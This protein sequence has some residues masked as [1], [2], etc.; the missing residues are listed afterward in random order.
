[1][2]LGDKER[3]TQMSRTLTKRYVCERV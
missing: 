1:M 2:L 3:S